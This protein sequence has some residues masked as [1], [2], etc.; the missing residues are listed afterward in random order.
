LA[1]D[2]RQASEEGGLFVSVLT[3]DA[4]AAATS[5]RSWLRAM[6]DFEVALARGEARAGAIPP[7]AAEAIVLCCRSDDHFD[8]VALGR[9][10][11]LSGNPGVALVGALRERLP[12]QAA[13]WAHFGAASQDMVDTALMLVL[14]QALS[15]VLGDLDRAKEAAAGLAERYRSAPM[16]ARTLLQQALPTTFG[17][18]AVGWLVALSE[19]TDA[20]DHVFHHRLALQLGGPAGTLAQL[21]EQASGVVEEVASQLGLLVPVVPWHTD[22]ARVVEASNAL[23]LCAGAAAKV[24]LDVSLMMQ[25]EVG[26]VF[27]PSAPGRGGSSSMPHKRN[28]AMAASV[29]AAWRRAQGQSAILLAAMP[30]EHERAVGAWQAEPETLS[31]LCRSVA[32]AVAVTADILEGLEVDTA[33]MARNLELSKDVLGGDLSDVARSLAQAEALVD[34]ALGLY[35]RAR[36]A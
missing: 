2:E 17:R 15:L 6:L 34:S 23:A 4:M 11:R 28:P 20:L 14:R 9:A 8:P 24:A 31:E 5:D 18:K 22:R 25:T 12:A 7:E 32:G 1:R 16:A 33:R 26:E 19:V 29:I 13:Q 21:G 27:E 10:G 36:S 3:T 30:Q 35:R